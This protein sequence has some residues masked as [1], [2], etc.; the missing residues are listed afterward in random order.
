VCHSVGGGS[1]F[2]EILR[3]VV[4]K[5][6]TITVIFFK[7][8][9]RMKIVQN[10]LDLIA[11]VDEVGR[12]PLAGAVV[13]AAVILQAD[14]GI[15]G[16]ADSK[17]LSEKKRERLYDE[18]MQ[19]ALAVSIGRAEV[20]EIDEINILNAALLAMQRAIESL[21]ITPTHVLVDGNRCPEVSMPITAVIKG[22]E[23]IESISAASIIAK[24]TRDR[25]ML[26]LDQQYPGYAFAA[27]K[28]YGTKKHMESLRELGPCPIHRRSFA[29]VAQ[30]LPRDM[31][32]QST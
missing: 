17:K 14:H 13:A 22:D 28:G 3:K 6:D 2:K 21:S 12:G 29:P 27:H 7:E 26:D 9:E 15:I 16:L 5:D 1:S 23:K 24:V 19:R 25:E 32:S 18:I 8:R 30:L 20:N 11:G 31:A 4:A 10:S